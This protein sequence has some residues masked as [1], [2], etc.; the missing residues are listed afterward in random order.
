MGVVTGLI[1]AGTA[2]YGAYQKKKA[3]DQAAAAI[4]SGRVDPNQ[5]ANDARTQAIENAR[6]SLELENQLT[7]ENQR[8]RRSSTAALQGFVGDQAGDQI[9]SD[10]DRQIAAGG[11]AEQSTLLTEAIAKARSDLALGGQLDSETRNEVS[12]R[13]I[14]EGGNTGAA[15]FTVARDLGL[16]SLDLST[17]RLERG[18]RFGQVEQNRF[19]AGFDNLSRLRELRDRLRSGQQSRAVQIAGFGQSLQPPDVGLAPGEFAGLAVGNQNLVSQAAM[20]R[21]A[22]TS[23][24]ASNFG[25]AISAA[26]GVLFGQQEDQTKGILSP[27]FKKG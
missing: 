24:N 15:R 13:A 22:N 20:Q 2:L 6:A 12:R 25:Q 16:R 10:V 5:V 8:L 27:I 1:M 3:G 7:P 17:E 4:E 26:G 18:G 9:V 11:D 14:S 19:Q 23:A 21:A